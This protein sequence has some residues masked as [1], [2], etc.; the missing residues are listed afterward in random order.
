MCFIPS[1][2]IGFSQPS[3]P[4]QVSVSRYTHTISTSR[5]EMLPIIWFQRYPSRQSHILLPKIP[6]SDKKQNFAGG[7]NPPSVECVEILSGSGIPSYIAEASPSARRSCYEEAWVQTSVWR[8]PATTPTFLVVWCILLR[9]VLA[10][11]DQRHHRI[12]WEE[13][14]SNLHLHVSQ[15]FLSHYRCS[16]PNLPLSAA[17]CLGRA[18][19]G[20]ACSRPRLQ[21][22]KGMGRRGDTAVTLGTA[23]TFFKSSE[24]NT[25][26]KHSLKVKVRYRNKALL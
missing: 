2:N 13:E 1:S 6:V 4:K 26:G 17:R 14:K 10:S 3:H 16:G 8:K 15:N 25:C 24:D 18:W 19:H 9:L 22:G 20:G 11:K 23:F 5:S 21:D 7:F 12:G